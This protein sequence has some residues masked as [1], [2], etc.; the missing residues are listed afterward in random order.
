MEQEHAG[1]FQE[2]ISP[3]VVAFSSTKGKPALIFSLN[4]YRV[5]DYTARNVAV[6]SLGVNPDNTDSSISLLNDEC[7]WIKKLPN[8]IV[9]VVDHGEKVVPFLTQGDLK[10]LVDY[11]I[12]H[13]AR[14]E[15]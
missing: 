7:L 1:M 3:N 12:K 2:Q 10:A 8:E 6:I 14:L 4:G 9:S 13:G 15:E 11:F 5:Y